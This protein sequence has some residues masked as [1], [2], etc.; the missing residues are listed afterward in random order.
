MLKGKNVLITGASRGIGAALA[1]QLAKEEVTLC[2]TARNMTQA[3]ELL[4]YLDE[5]KCSYFIIDGDMSVQSDIEEVYSYFSNQT[6]GIDVLVNNAGRGIFKPIHNE[7]P[8]SIQEI[9]NLNVFGLIYMTQQCTN[10]IVERQGTVVNIS[11]VAGRKGFQGLSVYCAS[12]WAVVGFSESLRDEL[13]SKGVRVL[14]VEP[15]LVDTEWG[16]ELPE[17]FVDY[18]NSVNML[19]ADDIA[20]TIM[21]GLKQPH[22]VSLNE[23]LIRP[24]NQPR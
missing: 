3:T 12:K 21:Y 22:H 9:L 11:S 1:K 19:S 5:K 23:I 17:G 14:T 8:E 18:K 4:A 10:D 2:L 13:C 15:G 7:T 24:T 6:S 16:E 20:E